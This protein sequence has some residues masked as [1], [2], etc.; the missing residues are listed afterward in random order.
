[1]TYRIKTA[2]GVIAEAVPPSAALVIE[3]AD[4]LAAGVAPWD[5]SPPAWGGVGYPSGNRGW[6]L[7]ALSGAWQHPRTGNDG[8]PIAPILNRLN[9]R[10]LLWTVETWMTDVRL[11]DGSQVNY[12]LTTDGATL[13]PEHW[14]MGVEVRSW[15]AVGHDGLYDWHHA[16]RTDVLGHAPTWQESIDYVTACL[17]AQGTW[18]GER[19]V[20][21]AG[22]S[23]RIARGMWDDTLPSEL[24][25]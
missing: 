13:Y 17:R 22:V 19:A 24:L 20:I 6:V 18:W 23:G 3:I 2:Q 25:R 10:A 7:P 8:R 5:W 12:E 4:K 16:G 21:R 1:M 15:W 11:P 9:R 14:L